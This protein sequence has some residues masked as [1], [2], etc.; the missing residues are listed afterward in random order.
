MKSQKPG[1]FRVLSFLLALSMIFSF[2]ILAFA[3]EETQESGISALATT[4]VPEDML[5]SNIL[6]ALIYLG[7][8]SDYYLRN[9]GLLFKNGYIASALNTNHAAALTGVPYANG[10]GTATTTQNGKTVPNVAS[11]K[12]NG[13][14]C[15]SFIEYYYLNYLRYIAGAA[16]T[17]IQNLAKTIRSAYSEAA[18]LYGQDPN[19]YPDLWSTAGNLLTTEAYGK[20]A[21]KS[22]LDKRYT[23]SYSTDE[24]HAFFDGL[25]I[26]SL[27]QFGSNDPS[28]PLNDYVHYAVYAGKYNGEYYVIH[29]AN[30]RGPEISLAR[31]M[32]ASSFK[33]SWPIAAYDFDPP[34]EYG[35]IEIY[36]SD[37]DG[38]PLAG[39]TFLAVH[40]ETGNEYFL[41][42]DSTGYAREDELPLGTYTVTETVAPV[43]YE[44]VDTVWTV[45]LTEE[46]PTGGGTI[47]VTNT[48][49]KGDLKI[50]KDILPSSAAIPGNL[51]GWQFNVYQNSPSY[52]TVIRD[53]VMYRVKVTDKNGNFVFSDTTTL[54]SEVTEP[55]EEPPIKITA[56]P[57]NTAASAGSTA[58]F[59]VS[60]Q[61]TTGKTL[62][63]QWYYKNASSTSWTKSTVASGKTATY[64]FNMATSHNG[65]TVKCLISDGTNEIWTEEVKLYLPTSL[66]VNSDPSDV[67]TIIG[68]DATFTATFFGSPTSFLWQYSA[69][70]G[71]TWTDCSGNA[72]FNCTNYTT[73][74]LTV[75]ASDAI[76]GYQFRC[77]ATKGT[78]T[79]TTDAATLTAEPAYIFTTSP[80]QGALVEIGG[81]GN[82]FVGVAGDNLTYQWQ[83][84]TAKS[85]EWKD[86][87]GA[88]TGNTLSL[89]MTEEYSNSRVRLQITQG[90]YVIY[91][92]PITFATPNTLCITMDPAATVAGEDGENVTLSVT[93]NGEGLV[94]QWEVSTDGGNTWISAMEPIVGNPYTTGEDGTVTIN[95]LPI[96][97][98]YVQEIDTG[99]ANWIY[100]LTPKAVTVEKDTTAT[101][102]FTNELAVGRLEIQKETNTGDRKD[103]WKV[104]VMQ[105]IDGNFVEIEGSPFTTDSTG[106]L[107]FENLLPGEYMVYEEDNGS[108]YWICDTAP[109]TVTVAVG[110]TTPVIITNTVYGKL[111]IK[112][113]TT[114]NSSAMGYQFNVYDPSGTLVPGSPFTT[115]SDGNFDLGYVLPGMYTVE[116]VLADDDAYEVVGNIRQTLEVKPEVETVF[117]FVNAPKVGSLVIQKQTNTGSSL[118]GWQF[119]VYDP[120]GNLLA[121]SPFTTDDVDGKITISNLPIGTYTVVEVN[122]GKEMW[123]YDLEEKSVTVPH[124]GTGTVIITN[125]QLGGGRIVK[126]TTNGG[127]KAGWQFKVWTNSA[128][129]GTFITDANGKI[130]LGLLYPGTYFVQEIG[131]TSMSSEELSYWTTDAQVKELVIVA[132]TTQA[133]SFTNEWL[134]IGKIVKT[135][136]SGTKEG[137]QFKVWTD[138]AELGIFTSDANGEINLG[139]LA[140][141]TYYV[142][143]VG[144]VNMTAKELIYWRMDTEIKKLEIVAGVTGSVFVN[145]T[146]F[147]MIHLEKSTSDSSS[148][149]NWRFDITDSDG[150]TTTHYTDAQGR[151]SLSLLPGTYTITEVIPADVMYEPQNGATYT[152]EV[153]AG[154][155]RVVSYVNEPIRGNVSIDK[156]DSNGKPVSNAGFVAVDSKGNRYNFVESAP[157]LYVL[158]NIP[159]DSYII[160]EEVVPPGFI[161]SGDNRWTVTLSK[162][163]RSETLN[164]TN[165][166]LGKV[167]ITKEMA[168]GSSATGWVFDIYRVSDNAFI[169]TYTTGADGTVTT[170]YLLPGD[171]CVIERVPEGSI[172]HPVGGAE[173][174]LTIVGGD[175]VS[176]KYVNALRA[177]E[178]I[179]NKVDG[180][181]DAAL[182]GAKFL[183]EWLDN[184]VW[185]PVI[186]SDTIIL[187]GCSSANL[188]NGCLVS[189][190][191]GLIV[192]YGLHPDCQYRLTE[193]DA[194][195]GYILQAGTLFEGKL[196]N[197]TL[198][199]AHTVYNHPNF[200]LPSTGVNNN[201]R[202]LQI[203]SLSLLTAFA[204][205][206]GF[207][208]NTIWV[209]RGKNNRK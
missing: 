8:D 174:V 63:Y 78:A 194:P 31:Y 205:V 149:E 189:G 160:T 35:S 124:N 7:Y 79:A 176:V 9:N 111:L 88:N 58:Q 71:N 65:R 15:T 164:I 169:G 193:I 92:A 33:K 107:L 197:D 70:G 49:L 151:I 184:D 114:D 118:G 66:G 95:G 122:D 73:N 155:I 173:K 130:D 5:N 178:I 45:E 20:V 147:G 123:I 129:Y 156:T 158:N 84:W 37:E 132:G 48:K 207:A 112:K 110:Q 120:N 96:G 69:D 134:G 208:I 54:K 74:T 131:H 103:G 67:S 51:A 142:Q 23:G 3:S 80:S 38:T 150:K 185:T 100:D 200:V 167:Q 1:V 11:F 126:D 159:I 139:K 41:F 25:S 94:Y 152:V 127:T 44:K 117:S 109:Q 136:N 153:I 135:T 87:V 141:G 133:V 104:H 55:V 181:T 28:N 143:E 115:D 116:E 108:D 76:S 22:T 59:S 121:G 162:T 85:G 14:V 4:D 170:D 90:E 163:H 26:G 62:T 187:G 6:K 168:D 10:G 125:T 188:E 195:D 157:G 204:L 30:S 145:N 140:P 18:K 165:I 42:S 203:L 199:S 166:A 191:D 64:S 177:G 89:T 24:Y 138:A 43:G 182:A 47:Y 82:F 179:I 46:N 56:Q 172:Y 102:T 119:N 77:V 192:F 19:A 171:Y 68:L 39:A 97:D 148:V 60:A 99:R 201:F 144:H 198:S 34:Q 83:V 40:Q 61:S 146:H 113:T 98:Y 101:V 154:Q 175:I 196:S 50:F 93:A 27:I 57:Q 202:W 186:Y 53:G 183:L 16:D 190:E 81:T 52:T 180:S 29:V 2:T 86:I 32:E 72:P 106:Y 91:S 128:D 12:A 21:K 105:N 209:T 137:W 36:K 13:M 17:E 206:V 75:I 161:V